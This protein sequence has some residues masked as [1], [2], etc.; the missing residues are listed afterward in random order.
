LRGREDKALETI[1]YQVK[2]LNLN[3]DIQ[4]EKILLVKR[5]LDTDDK[6][7]LQQVKEV[8]KNITKK[9]FGT[10]CPKM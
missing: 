5:L 6:A 8:F 10:T 3:M 9:I 1:R 7:I 2:I 4:T